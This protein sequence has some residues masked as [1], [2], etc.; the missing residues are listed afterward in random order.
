MDERSV[1]CYFLGTNTAAGFCSLYSE[2]YDP[3]SGWRCTVLKGG[4]GS[5]KSTILRKLAEAACARGER[6]ELV[7]CASDPRS[8]DA[9][10]LPDSRKCMADGTAPHVL[11]PVVPGACETLFN[12]GECWN[13][14]AL[15]AHR[16]EIR[17]LNAKIATCHRRAMQLKAL[18]CNLL[19]EARTLSA[20]AL[21]RDRFER[22]L[23][24]LCA[25]LF[26]GLPR[27]KGREIKRFLAAVTPN[28]Y[29]LQE[30]TL[31]LSADRIALI[32]D[33]TNVCAPFI[34]QAIRAAALTHGCTVI[35]CFDP[36]WPTELNAVI[37]PEQS[38]AFATANALHRFALIPE[39]TIHV[40]RFMLPTVL[41]ARRGI[42]RFHRKTA[43][44][45]LTDVYAQ[46][47]T[48]LELHDEL[49]E[50][51]KS[52]MD[53][54]LLDRKTEVLLQQFFNA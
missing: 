17:R 54:T 4:P 52:A 29:V 51:Y 31:S 16:A 40:R 13:N 2:M 11:E 33:D 42:I 22:Y 18:A 20:E 6:V 37:L 24:R 35:S 39:R 27:Q 21:Q 3:D 53:F 49:E 7:H 32:D 14:Q 1:P 47:R 25:R 36:L 48:A 46:L 44:A 41:A 10:I 8:L 38:Q 26:R 12:P 19:D 34:L 23:T 30:H 9:V 15:F 28:G 5:G 43:L 45:L 50:Y